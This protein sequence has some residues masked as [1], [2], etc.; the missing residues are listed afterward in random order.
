MSRRLW[1]VA[2]ECANPR[3]GG[4]KIDYSGVDQT[5]SLDFECSI[6]RR[7]DWGASKLLQSLATTPIWLILV[8]S[9]HDSDVPLTSS[10]FSQFVPPRI[11]WMVAVKGSPLSKASASR[12]SEG[13]Y[14]IC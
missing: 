1:V 9:E 11:A 10:R 8:H 14:P 3:D 4:T 5:L 2:S 7:I 6:N 12:A 13:R